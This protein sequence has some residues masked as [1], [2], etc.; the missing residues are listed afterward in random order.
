MIISSLCEYYG[1]MAKN[2]KVT[3]EGYSSQKITHLVCLGEDGVIKDI[4]P[5]GKKEGKKDVYPEM[6]FPL[7]TQK[8]G[9]DANFIEHRPLYIFGLNYEN[10]VFTPDDRTRKAEKS[11]EAF[12]KRN[13]EIVDGLSDPLA[14]AFGLFIKKWNPSAETE[15][16]LLLSL[17]GAYKT[18]CFAFCLS[19]KINDYLQDVKEIK[20]KWEGELAT[21]GD[22]SSPTAMCPVY[23]EELPV[24]KLHDK[25][26]GVAGGQ[27]SGCILVCFNND[28][29]NS[30]GKEQSYNSGISVRAMKEYT[31]A[32]NYLLKTPGHH[33]LMDGMTVCFFAMTDKNE[34]DYA[35]AISFSF[36]FNF[37]E[38]EAKAEEA[39]GIKF[40]VEAVDEN[41]NSAAKSAAA[42]R[43]INFSYFDGLDE[44]VQ[45]CIFGLVPN[46]SRIMI[47]FF[48]RDTFS[49]LRKNIEKWHD[50]FAVG[51]SAGAPEFW[52]IRKQLVSPKSTDNLPPDITE[53][54]LNGAING[55]PLP[56]KILETV[57]RRIKTDSD[58]E[59]SHS[60]KMNDARI[61]LLK[62]CLN[63]KN[64]DRKEEITVSLNFENK[65]P[66]YLCGRLF[67]ALEKIQQDA[68][69]GKLNKTIK[70]TYFSSAAATPATVFP[71]LLKLS[72]AHQAKLE[73]GR[74]VYCNRLIGSILDGLEDFPRTL[75]LEQQG[76]FIIGYYQQNQYFYT[77]KADK[78]EL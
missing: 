43:K 68:A 39:E 35:N 44:S 14:K 62:T 74:Q 2:G 65:N 51:G 53:C 13:Y 50:D 61:G 8:P 21:S 64:K 67:A 15:N 24:A 12:V 49:E 23:G 30:Y 16:K 31:E 25:I 40:D 10:G 52:K 17:G 33:I 28:S 57:I 9:I 58:G 18:A 42:G 78:E 5:V 36:S 73:A 59:K 3:K 54:L 41:L 27:A 75:S 55:T 26:K 29:E 7:R 4:L 38:A 66:A 46:S 77:A 45:Y 6:L 37:L 34:D 48:Y 71:V 19:G 1:Y 22:D 47:K 11:H 69:G 20:D 56:E 70:D 76:S 32:L 60:I 63:R 72:G